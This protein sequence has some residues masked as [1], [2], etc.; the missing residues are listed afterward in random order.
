MS[1]IIW[2]LLF[3]AY[4]HSVLARLCCGF[5]T[6]NVEKFAFTRVVVFCFDIKKHLDGRT[7]ALSVVAV[8]LQK[9]YEISVI[10]FSKTAF[11][12]N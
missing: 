2:V 4:M 5:H 10:L 12:C 9:L 1:M 6:E 8:L 11:W 7:M 3:Y